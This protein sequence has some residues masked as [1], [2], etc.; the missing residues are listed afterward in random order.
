MSARLPWRALVVLLAGLV[1]AG[2]ASYSYVRF[3]PPIQNVELRNTERT[4]ARILIAWRGVWKHGEVDELRFRVRFENLGTG[5]FA[6]NESDFEL[7]DGALDSFGPARAEALPLEIPAGGNAT[8]ELAFPAERPLEAYD[9]GALNL[10]ARFQDGR[11]NSTTTFERV[12]PSYSYYD[13]YYP[14]YWGPYW[15][16][17]WG[18]PWH[19]HGGVV[20]YH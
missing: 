15:G 10:R 7:M 16:P 9:L 8:F 17:Y 12:E 1:G 5:A 2:C 3:G 19:F 13:P 11:W 6:L 14:Y 4:E 18:G 20:W